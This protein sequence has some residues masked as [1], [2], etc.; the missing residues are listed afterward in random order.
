MLK[1]QFFNWAMASA[2]NMKLSL[3]YINEPRTIKS[4]IISYDPSLQRAIEFALG[5][6]FIGFIKTGTFKLSAKGEQFLQY[7]INDETV[8]VPEKEYLKIVSTK[9]ISETQVE[10][11]VK[12]IY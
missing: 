6:E 12:G 11:I 8:L 1:L 5:D 4:D 2:R 9:S 10:S 3:E 7:L